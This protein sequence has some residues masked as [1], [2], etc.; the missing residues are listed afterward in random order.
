MRRRLLKRLMGRQA[1]VDILVR[2]LLN[3]NMDNNRRAL[4]AHSVGRDRAG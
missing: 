2:V 1:C 4:R 3:T